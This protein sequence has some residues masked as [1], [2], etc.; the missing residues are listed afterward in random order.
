MGLNDE[1]KKA[2]RNLRELF[3]DQTEYVNINFYDDR[4]EVEDYVDFYR[5]YPLENWEL[6]CEDFDEHLMISRGEEQDIEFSQFSSAVDLINKGLPEDL[7]SFRLGNIEAK[8][9]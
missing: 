8:R 7:S 5:V 3:E 9:V 1:Q 6:S 4:T 2:I